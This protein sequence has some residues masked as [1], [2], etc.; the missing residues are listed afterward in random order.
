MGIRRPKGGESRARR[1]R[2]R[3]LHRGIRRALMRL[4][5]GALFSTVG[6]SPEGIVRVRPRG[7]LVALILA[8]RLVLDICSAVRQRRGP[9]AL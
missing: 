2:R 5:D 9:D 7:W 6:P 1:E 8:W 3:R 4:P